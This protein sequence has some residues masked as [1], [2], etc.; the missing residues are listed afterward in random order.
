MAVT[1]RPTV[2][3]QNPILLII[4]WLSGRPRPFIVV[5][6]VNPTMKK[7]VQTRALSTPCSVRPW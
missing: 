1:T 4:G 2:I 3:I 7:V 5:R 6:L